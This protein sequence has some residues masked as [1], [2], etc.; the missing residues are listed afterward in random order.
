MK[1]NNLRMSETYETEHPNDVKE[2]TCENDM[3]LMDKEEL[4]S[5][6]NLII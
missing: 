3:I 2:I 5:F 4:L 6:E 1:Q